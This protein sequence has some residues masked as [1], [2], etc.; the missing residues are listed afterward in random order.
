MSKRVVIT[1]VN[2]FVGYH[3]S[4]QLKEK[5]YQT[6]GV[7]MENTPFEK[8]AP[9]LD[10]YYQANLIETWPAI[11]DLYGIIHLAGL[12]AVGPSFDKPQLYINGNTAMVTNICEYYLKNE[13]KPKMLVISSGAIY[14]SNQE[15]PIKETS[16]IGFGSP[17]SVSKV[18]VENQVSYYRN[19][20]FDMVVA[21]PFNHIGQGQGKGFLV[22][23]LYH[24]MNEL[25]KD[26]HE[27]I[28]GNIKTA[29]DYTDVRDI[30]SAYIQLIEATNL[31]SYVFNIC[32]GKSHTGEEIFNLIAKRLGRQDIQSVV[33]EE[34]V[35]P[36]DVMN[37]YGSS[38][39]LQSQT[40]W[41]P[42]YALEESIQSFI[43]FEN[44]N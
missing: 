12:A 4:K 8:V 35:R 21:R 38:Q 24:R 40:N 41:K 44:N 9:F 37:I 30:A 19:R 39:L 17:Y 6:I 18:A 42:S 36:T 43:D 13:K 5:G 2:G 14:E 28:V 29:R 31:T 15:L 1:G 23:D 22:P 10:E 3:L 25:S 27:I 16:T 33:N 20:G 7:S 11:D 32:S 34:L 26:E